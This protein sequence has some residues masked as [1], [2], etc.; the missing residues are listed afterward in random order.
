MW[1]KVWIQLRDPTS[2][3][4]APHAEAWLSWKGCLAP[5][6]SGNRVKIVTASIKKCSK[7]HSCLYMIASTLKLAAVTSSSVFLKHTFINIPIE[8]KMT[9]LMC[10]NDDVAK[11]WFNS[12]VCT[13]LRTGDLFISISECCINLSYNMNHRTPE[14]T[15]SKRLSLT[16]SKCIQL[17]ALHWSVFISQNT[18]KYYCIVLPVFILEWKVCTK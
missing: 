14:F 2:L 6:V 11:I 4:N 18:S 17:S 5:A 10:A 7:S 13:F 1:K 15:W 16:V 8:D 3:P 9:L 12:S